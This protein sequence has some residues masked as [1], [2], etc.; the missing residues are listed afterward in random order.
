MI[1][2]GK[3][4]STIDL[5][6]QTHSGGVHSLSDTIDGK[7]VDDNMKAKHP[8]PSQSN[9]QT[10][11]SSTIHRFSSKSVSVT[12]EQ[13]QWKDMETTGHLASTRKNGEE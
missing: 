1:R 4:S 12:S 11:P 2:A 3:I 9:P 5:L 10:K 8:N 7:S 13:L 6:A